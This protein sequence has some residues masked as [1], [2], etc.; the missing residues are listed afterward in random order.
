MAYRF[1]DELPDA[2]LVVLDDAGHF[3]WEDAPERT[4]SELV[5]FLGR[6]FS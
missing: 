6:R 3:V 1:K 4:S 2:E 5:E